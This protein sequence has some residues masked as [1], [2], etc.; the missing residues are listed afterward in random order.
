MRQCVPAR[1]T[2]GDDAFPEAGGNSRIGVWCGVRSRMQQRPGWAR[3][4]DQ[5]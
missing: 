5:S 2:G 1:F 4:K 3:T